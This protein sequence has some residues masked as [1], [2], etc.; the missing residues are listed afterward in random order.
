MKINEAE[1]Y[2]NKFDEMFNQEK[3]GMYTFLSFRKEKII[4]NLPFDQTKKEA[5][6]VLEDLKKA[7]SDVKESQNEGQDND[8]GVKRRIKD[9]NSQ[10]SPLNS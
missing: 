5:N 4:F 7:I 1:K 8:A 10:S 2:T 3:L 6:S 9:D